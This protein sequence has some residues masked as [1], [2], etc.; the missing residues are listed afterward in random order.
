MQ[1]KPFL[2]SDIKRHAI[3]T[4]RLVPLLPTSVAVASFPD[5]ASA[6]RAVSEALNL[7]ASIRKSIILNL[8]HSIPNLPKECAELFDDISIRALNI[9]ASFPTKWPERDTVMF[10]FQ[11]SP[12]VRDDTAQL[13]EKAI[14]KHG[15]SGFVHVT[16]EEDVELLWSGR[17]NMLFGVLKMYPGMKGFIT[18]VW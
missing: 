10:K 6:T 5:V 18:D 7:G 12:I 3:A 2:M 13:V 15:G 9:A 11:G 4:I 14:S 8:N 17:K 1:R 16:K